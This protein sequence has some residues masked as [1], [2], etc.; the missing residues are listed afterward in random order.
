MTAG[1]RLIITVVLLMGIEPPTPSFD[2]RLQLNQLELPTHGRGALATG[3]AVARCGSVQ[4]LS[5]L[6]LDKRMVRGINQRLDQVVEKRSVA[7][8]DKYLHRHPRMK[9]VLANAC[10]QKSTDTETGEANV[11]SRIID[12]LIK[13]GT[14]AVP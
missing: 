5:N 10:R 11:L 3:E 8:A 2:M 14:E 12:S 6:I 7:G 1:V 9:I 4:M 13:S